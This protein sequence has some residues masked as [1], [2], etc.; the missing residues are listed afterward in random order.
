MLSTLSVC[1]KPEQRR[2]NT[3]AMNRKWSD[4]RG[5]GRV[6]HKAVTQ[7]RLWQGLSPESGRA[8]PYSELGSK[9]GRQKLLH[10]LCL[11]K[12]FKEFFRNHAYIWKRGK[13]PQTT[14]K[15][16][17]FE[18]RTQSFYLL[19]VFLRMFA[20]QNRLPKRKQS[21]IEKAPPTFYKDPPTGELYGT[22]GI[23]CWYSKRIA[24]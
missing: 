22:T 24:N 21:A 17:K 15:K 20:Q 13:L 3:E 9:R 4:T 7:I 16:E 5:S 12:S 10:S 23:D 18:L 2:R 6:A 11:K 8:L 19:H 14:I 1:E